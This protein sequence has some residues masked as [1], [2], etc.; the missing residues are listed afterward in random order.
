MAVRGGASGL[1]QEDYSVN[2]V[3]NAA[4][5]YI[6]KV[7]PNGRWLIQRYVDATGVFDYANLSNNTG[8]TSYGVAWTNRATLTYAAYE[9]LAGV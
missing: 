9:T 8:T 5:T 6:G 3:E 4:T 7:T 1:Y 2:N